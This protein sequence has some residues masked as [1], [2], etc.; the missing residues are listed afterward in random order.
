V[1]LDDMLFPDS[2][3]FL[4]QVQPNDNT[5]NCL[6][7]LVAMVKMFPEEFFTHATAFFNATLRGAFSA[8]APTVAYA[9]QLLHARYVAATNI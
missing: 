8:G 6:R 7:K 3:V 1:V 5:A 4:V 9:R 2:D